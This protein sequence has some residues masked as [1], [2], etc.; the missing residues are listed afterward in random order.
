MK[1][2]FS[3]TISLLSFLLTLGFGVYA[4]KRARE[5][6]KRGTELKELGE[7]FRSGLNDIASSISTKYI[8]KFP[9]NML[10]INELIKKANESI[11]IITDVAAYGVFSNPKYFQE[12]RNLLTNHS[13]QKNDENVTIEMITYSLDSY[14]LRFEE[15]FN[16]QMYQNDLDKFS[17]IK[18]SDLNRF[19]QFCNFISNKKTSKEIL[20]YPDLLNYLQ[21]ENYKIIYGLLLNSNFNYYE[22]D[23]KISRTNLPM[24]I[25]IIDN[26]AA[27]YSFLD[28][29][30]TTS[31]EVSFYTEDKNVIDM[32]NNNLNELVNGTEQSKK[33]SKKIE[34]DEFVKKYSK[35]LR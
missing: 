24:S 31:G 11:S 15:Q 14:Q 10:Q 16:L 30:A 18:N 8:G 12:Y 4:I 6:I 33:K 20:S 23:F 26:K 9:S 7:E 35:I 28:N 27:I 2:P 32:L 21:Q 34:Q 1:L 13:A 19:Q 3:T 25:W 17:D 5:S 29:F 22:I